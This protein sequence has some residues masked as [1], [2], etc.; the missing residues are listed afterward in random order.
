MNLQTNIALTKVQNP[1]TYSSELLLMGSCFSENIGGKL[2]LFKFKN[3]SN[4]F[5]II[6]HAEA[7][8]K[9]ILKAVN[10]E[11]FQREDIFFQNERWHSFDVHSSL[12]DSDPEA[13]LQKLNRRLSALENSLQN[14]NHIFITLGTAWVY[15]HIET[16][17]LV[18]NC[19]K[20]PQKRFIKELRSSEQILQSLEAISAVVKTINP[21]VHIVLTISPVR[22]LKD[23]FVENQRSKS[24][25]ITAVHEW[26]EPRKRQYY[27]PAYEL[28]M[29]ELRDY[30]FYA[31]DMMHPNDV[32]VR[33]I[34]ERFRKV[35]ISDNAYP[36]MEEVEAINKGLAHKPFN[37]GSEQHRQFRENLE[38]RIQELTKNY[39]HMVFQVAGN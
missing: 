29:D 22:H 33:Y 14:A 8:E 19:H 11:K 13:L 26:T 38:T 15:R 28:M 39:P 17:T 7:I 5:G 3:D 12:S 35:W 9:L 37:P 23:G 24:H 2:D 18:A 25:L 4:P 10:A 31:E 27:F 30:R 34:W 16:D 32:A 36:T 21:K 1:I 6:F 20:V